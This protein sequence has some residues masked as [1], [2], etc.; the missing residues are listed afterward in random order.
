MLMLVS[1]IS[2]C[3][4]AAAVTCGTGTKQWTGTAGDNLWTTASNW[5]GGTVPVATDNVCIASTFSANTIT[6]FSLD[7]ANQ[8]ISK[9]TSGAPINLFGGPLTISGTATFTTLTVTS[10]TLTLN[11]TSS[12]STLTLNGGTLTGPST[13]TVTGLTTWGSAFMSGTGVT[14]ANGG[15]SMPSGQPTLDTR[16]VSVGGTSTFGSGTGAP[17][18]VMQNGGTLNLQAGAVWNFVNDG[19]IRNNGGTTPV[20]NNAGTFEKTAGTGTTNISASFNNNAGGTV[21]ANSGTLSLNGGGSGAVP[22]SIASGAK[23]AFGGGTTDLNSGTN[24]TGAGTVAI[25]GGTV[26]FNSGSKISAAIEVDSG[27]VT[28]STG[29][30]NTIASLTL[31]GG[32]LTGPDTLTVTGLT[33]WGS[34]FMSGTGVTNANGG[35]SMPSGQPTLDTRAVSVGGTSTFGSGT[36]APLFV[37]QNGG[38]LNVQ[39]GAVWNL[40]NDGEIRNNGGTTPVINN[41]GTFEKTAG[42]G[43]TN[44][45]A[46]FNN[47]A[48]GTVAANSGTM[49]M[50]GGGS[51]AATYSIASGAKLSFGGGTFALNRGTKV[52]GAGTTVMSSST[53][54]LNSGAKISAAMEVDSGTVTLTTGQVN[55]IASLTLNGGTLTGPDTLTVTGLTTWGSAFMSGS[56]ITNA[57]GGISMPPAGPILDTRT[58]NAGGTSTFGTSAGG[59]TLFMQNGGTLNVQ[60]GAVWNIVND[61]SFSNNGGTTPVINNLGTFEKTA[62]T[63]TTNIGPIFNNSGSLI[64]KSGALVFGGA[65]TQTNGSTSLSGGT[66][67]GALFDEQAGSFNVKGTITGNL[68]NT[69]GLVDPGFSVPTITTGTLTIGGTGTYTQGAAGT[70]LLNVGGSASSQFD[71]LNPVG[72]ANL[73][74][75]LYLCVINNFQ[76]KQGSTFKVMQYAS[77][78]GQFSTVESGWTPTYAATSVTV[79]YNGAAA[80]TFS[81]QS[82]TFPIQQVG[83]STTQSVSLTSSGILTLNISSITVTGSNKSDF[84]ISSDNCGA[85]LPVGS[86]CEVGVTFTPPVAGKRSAQLSVADDA[87]GL[88]QTVNL[89]GTGTNVTL[90]PSPADFG[91]ETVGVTSGPLDVTLTNHGAKAITVKNVSIT[92][93]NAGDFAIL[94]NTCTS[95]AGGGTCTI[96][97]TFTP[98]ATGVRNAT[99]SVSD[100]DGGSPQ[101]DAL[102]GTGT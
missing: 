74:G 4:A 24:V 42:T 39:A 99:L 89:N 84:K 43:T 27:T 80:V 50:N 57:N 64:A 10:G 91:S 33:T 40:V 56:G 2:F 21:A 87:C 90:S 70:L 81:P 14:N 16:A 47:N 1:W 102:T 72:I 9:L 22:Y 67:S 85:S 20:I 12:A 13:L 82:L 73:N 60:A 68:S 79:T 32:T 101:T 25:G 97:L 54:N 19:E 45:S 75:A 3:C 18:F 63:G 51:G 77:H 62:G 38:T 58:V 52:S 88:P 8:T 26:N 55:T 86:S 98:Q 28:L 78:S 95:V 61:G 48:G 59:P 7:P 69:A 93:A 76:P 23:L 37:M 92:G 36:G 46:S 49:S 96:T 71:Q 34:A 83:T 11:G 6:I 44:I 66:I 41:A 94:S 31:N 15:I 53:V 30:T 65:F 100:T 35:I 17:L 29:Q 5:S